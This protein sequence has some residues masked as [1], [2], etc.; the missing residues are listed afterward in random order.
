MQHPAYEVKF[1]RRVYRRL[2]SRE[3]TRL[4]EDFCG[5]AVLACEWVRR[6][7]GGEALGLDLHAPTLRWARLHNVA[8]LGPRAGSVRLEVRDVLTPDPPGRRRFRPDVAVALNFSYFVFKEREVLREYFRRVRASLAPRGIFVL[9]IY[10]GPEA[11]KVQE[12]PRQC[13]GFTY[14]WDQRSYNP[15][16]GETRCAIHFRVPG[17]RTLRRAFAYDWRL[18]SLPEVRD[19]LGEVGFRQIAVYWEGTD[20]ENG[21]GNGVFR[22]GK[23]GDDSLG[24]VAYLVAGK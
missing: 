8:P 14:V 19:L 2:R 11:Q 7:P 6:I 4:R 20:R 13:K 9:D 3:P 16:T 1:I 22:L 21:T 5:T 17:R 10:G 15:I 23:R 24:W 12:E 18:W